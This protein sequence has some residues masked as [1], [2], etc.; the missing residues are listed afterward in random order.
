MRNELTVNPKNVSKGNEYII[1][2]GATQQYKLYNPIKLCQM[3][4]HCSPF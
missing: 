4:A 1:K 3:Y 2:K